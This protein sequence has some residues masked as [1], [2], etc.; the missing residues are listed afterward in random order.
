MYER[1][2]I[3]DIRIHDYDDIIIVIMR[4][5]G[6]LIKITFLIFSAF[7]GKD[8]RY[9]PFVLLSVF[10]TLSSKAEQVFKDI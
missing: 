5:K 7:S 8:S 9:C 6:S 4:N 3:G 10:H 1:L 2:F